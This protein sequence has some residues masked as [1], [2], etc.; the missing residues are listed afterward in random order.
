L[1]SSCLSVSQPNPLLLYIQFLIRYQ[2]CRLTHGAFVLISGRIGAIYGHK[3][4]LLVGGAWWVLWSVINGFCTRSLITFA[5]A[6]AFAGI[7]AA[8]VMPNIVAIIGITFPPG[9]MRNF[10]LGF[11]GF[12]CPVGGALGAFLMGVFIEFVEWRWFY[13]SMSVP[14]AEGLKMY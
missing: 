6:R 13:F 3:K 14:N 7:G 1:D 8:F 11:F 2:K 4:I 10:T 9:K 5:I 12:G